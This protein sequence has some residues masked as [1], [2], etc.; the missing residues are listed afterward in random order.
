MLFCFDDD[1]EVLF[2]SFFEGDLDGLLGAFLEDGPSE[3]CVLRAPA[4]F[5]AACPFDGRADCPL[6][7]CFPFPGPFTCGLDCLAGDCPFDGRTDWLRPPPGGCFFVAFPLADLADW[8]L[9][10]CPLPADFLLLPG[11]FPDGFFYQDLQD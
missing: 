8:P 5:L 9:A 7:G 3:D 1:F 4:C 11:I 2:G 10:N 6:A